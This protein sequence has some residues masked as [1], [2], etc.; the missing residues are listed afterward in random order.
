MKDKAL[1][2]VVAIVV[3][4]I[5]TGILVFSLGIFEEHTE[6]NTKVLSGII[7]GPAN[8]TPIE[9]SS[10]SEELTSQNWTSSYFDS[11]HGVLYEIAMA[12]NF[13]FIK[14]LFLH[15]GCMK[16][17][18]TKEYNG[19]KWDIYHFNGIDYKSKFNSIISLG[20]PGFVYLCSA[21][22]ENGEYLVIV[23]SSYVVSDDTLDSDLFKNYCEPFLNTITLKNPTNPPKEYQILDIS[24][25]DYN[26]LKNFVKNNGWDA[27]IKIASNPYQVNY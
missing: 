12:D 22:G 8:E 3:I 27:F 18:A 25:N 19:N 26:T 4:I 9:N 24:L 23:E 10:F 15:T 5:A 14:D 16:K 6:V 17:V 11:T 2:A 20:F 7:S 13:N 1:L 21:S